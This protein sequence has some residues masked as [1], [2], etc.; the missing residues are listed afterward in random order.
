MLVRHQDAP[1]AEALDFWWENLTGGNPPTD[2]G[3]TYDPT[4][5]LLDLSKMNDDIDRLE[6]HGEDST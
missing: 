4:L 1:I 2:I 5:A 6:D 3:M